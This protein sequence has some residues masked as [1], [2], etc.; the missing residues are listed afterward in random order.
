MNKYQITEYKNQQLKLIANHF[1]IHIRNKHAVNYI[2]LE[3]LINYY[4][5][6]YSFSLYNVIY[7]SFIDYT[8]LSKFENIHFIKLCRYF[9]H[10]NKLNYMIKN[11]TIIETIEKHDEKFILFLFTINFVYYSI[12]KIYID[13]LNKHMF[14]GIERTRLFKHRIVNILETKIPINKN[15]PSYKKFRLERH[16]NNFQNMCEKIVI[17]ISLTNTYYYNIPFDLIMKILLG[18]DSYMFLFN[19]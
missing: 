10:H 5:D 15:I 6:N 1:N 9:E 8:S 11:N 17:F 16:K 7:D 19:C 18:K 2:S 4:I 13:K 14:A 12:D 3:E